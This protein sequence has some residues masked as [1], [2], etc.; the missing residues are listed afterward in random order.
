MA[1]SARIDMLFKGGDQLARLSKDLKGAGRKDLRK[2]LLKELRKAG[3]P[4][5]LDV[6]RAVLAT[7]S[8]GVP[9]GS[10]SHQGGVG[11]R[12]AIARATGLSISASGAASI[13]IRVNSKKVTPGTLPKY[14]DGELPAF[15]GRWRHRTFG[16]GT[17][18]DGTS[19]WH[20]QD[21]HPFFFRTVRSH[22]DEFREAC[23]AA[24]EATA[25][26]LARG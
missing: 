9:G 12:Q 6:R 20:P 22:A 3:R 2:D 7:P 24:M 26:K 25:E 17:W 18:P 10:T 11:L 8:S 23:L 19:A 16:W 13:R 21:S 5:V 14:L 1:E 15:K 4:T